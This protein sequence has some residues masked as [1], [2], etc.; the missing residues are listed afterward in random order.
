MLDEATSALDTITEA[1]LPRSKKLSKNRTT[2]LV[3]H[4]LDLIKDADAIFV[5]QD[6]KVVESGNHK[7][8]TR[9]GKYY[10]S[11]L[12]AQNSEIQE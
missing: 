6:G 4:K 10:T 1:S 8:L 7:E 3:A 9:R 11:L 2:I 5:L 12:E